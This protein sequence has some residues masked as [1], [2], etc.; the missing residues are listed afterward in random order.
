ML[1]AHGVSEANSSFS[2]PAG[3]S[4]A[5]FW[6]FPALLNITLVGKSIFPRTRVGAREERNNRFTDIMECLLARRIAKNRVL[7]L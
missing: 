3:A 5:D 6:Q 2:C 1:M 4:R 7:R